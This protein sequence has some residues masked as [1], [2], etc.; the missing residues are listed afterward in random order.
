MAENII[1]NIYGLLE[2][3]NISSGVI[4]DIGCEL[5][6]H[7]DPVKETF[8][9]IGIS[10]NGSGTYKH[11]FGSIKADV[12]FLNSINQD[13]KFSAVVVSSLQ[14]YSLPDGI[15][16]SVHEFAKLLGI[17]A[18]FVVGNISHKDIALKL[19]EGKSDF[20]ENELEF[21]QNKKYYNEKS[22][23]KL[24]LD[25]GFCEIQK[26]D[27]ITHSTAPNFYDNDGCN[28]S[29]AWAHQYIEWFKYLVDSNSQ[30]AY[31][32]RA[33]SAV[34][35]PIK[36]IDVVEKHPFL[37]VLTRTQGKRIQA[38]T[39]TILCLTAQTDIDFELLIVGHKLND[40]QKTVVKDIVDSQPTWLREKIRFIEVNNGTRTTPLNIGFSEARGQYVAILDDDDV[41]LDNWVEEFH[42]LAEEFPGT[43]LHSYAFTQKWMAV[44]TVSSKD[45]LRAQSSMYNIHCKNFDLIKQLT[46]NNCPPVALAFPSYA[47]KDFGI[48]FDETLNT[49]EDWDY[50]MRV[51][52]VCGVSDAKT[53]TCIYRLWTN[54]ETSQTLHSKKE[55]KENHLFIQ[56]KFQNIPIVFPIGASK[57]LINSN[58]EI[59]KQRGKNYLAEAMIYFDRGEGFN[60]A[61][62]AL[63]N[64]SDSPEY[65]LECSDISEFNNIKS[66]RFDPTING[67]I[68]LRNIKFQLTDNLGNTINYNIK[69]IITNGIIIKDY[70]VFL[71][72]D[73]QILITLKNAKMFENIKIGFDIFYNIPDELIDSITN[74]C[75]KKSIIYRLIYK[76]FVKLRNILRRI[77]K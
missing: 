49:T 12:D 75:F 74:S 73:P 59:D 29:K 47:F 32:I 53:P 20:T 51:C 15:I 48:Q 9:F 42:K 77:K 69:N 14:K 71:K 19:I 4:L 2:N 3:L 8:K 22:L 56:N 45:S 63:F 36:D 70:I 40:S 35:K 64:E 10:E 50:L 68:A 58:N 57:S 1:E 33:Y 34:E 6:F 11:N 28:T 76:I 37:S 52:F 24:L 60:A 5:Y 26:N 16:N 55:W 54:T 30:T 62:S 18:I 41:V 46:I 43:I 27:I 61:D 65:K 31:F 7:S 67:G 17:P 21:F 13:N 25:N 38:L 23:N 39:E 66:I 44:S 72:S